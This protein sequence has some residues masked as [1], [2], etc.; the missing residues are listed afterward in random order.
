VAE[1]I[2]RHL[3]A[4]GFRI[5]RPVLSIGGP[6]P[7]YDAKVEHLAG[8]KVTHNRLF[9]SIGALIE[10]VDTF[11]IRLSEAPPDSDEERQS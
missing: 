6:D 4:L 8:R 11:F 10:A 9:G 3:W 7:D 5:V 2:R 1:T